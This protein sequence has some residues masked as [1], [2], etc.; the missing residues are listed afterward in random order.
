V[1]CLYGSVVSLCTEVR[2]RLL[3]DF[4]VYCVLYVQQPCDFVGF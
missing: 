4:V 1:L 3:Q 2:K